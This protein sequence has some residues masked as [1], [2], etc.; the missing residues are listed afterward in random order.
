MSNRMKEAFDNVHAEEEL[1]RHTRNHL[2]E[3]I[4]KRKTFACKK[5]ASALCCCVLLLFGAGGYS[6]YF[7]QTSAISVDVN[8]SIELGINQFDKVISVKGY[9]DDGR[10]IADSLDIRFLDYQTALKQLLADDSMNPYLTADHLLSITVNSTSEE[11]NNEMLVK[12]NTCTSHI[13][14]KI[15]YSAGSSEEADEAHE[16]GMSFGKYKAFLELQ[17]LDPDITI[18]EVQGM[19]M[20][21]I[22]D[23]ISALTDNSEPAHSAP[24][25]GSKHHQHKKG[26]VDQ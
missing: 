10:R 23:R 13:S 12:V 22:Q 4:Y 17:K 18:E 1:K 11:K 2:A 5:L 24:H 16:V 19:T 20:R 8:P 3:T 15:Y 14:G 9:N 6:L 21:Q 7:T 26:D 25:N